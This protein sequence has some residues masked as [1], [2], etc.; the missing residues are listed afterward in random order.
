MTTP[1]TANRQG[2]LAG[3]AAGV[4]W[5]FVFLSPQIL[6]DFSP[7]AIALGRF[8][9]FGLISLIHARSVWRVWTVLDAKARC[10]VVALSAAGFW[11]YTV[12]LVWSVQ[13]NGAVITT[14]V[15]G[16]LPVTIAL[17][18]HRAWPGRLTQLGLALIVG[19]LLL[20]QA[21][22]TDIASA[23][24][25]V[26]LLGLGSLLGCVALWTWYSLAS[27]RFLHHHPQVPKNIFISMM[28]LISLIS[29]M[30]TAVLVADP[31]TLLQQP[32]L[33]TFG[34]WSLIVGVGA[35]WVAYWLWSLTTTHCPPRVSGP[36]IVS[37]TLFGLV[38]SFAYAQ[39][40]PEAHEAAAMAIFFAGALL[41]I[42]A[43][44]GRQPLA[45]N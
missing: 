3:L 28:G 37:E 21:G 15:I 38:Y 44:T 1:M 11:L 35:T 18:G 32:R 22:K 10:F 25:S 29:L 31:T 36:L 2:I 20:L 26:T 8:L 17:A 39:R 16:L 12:L 42:G 24:Q 34:I 45:A 23:T 27:A 41:C 4:L 6:H 33:G 13:H 7:F 9:C 19:G 43:K 14:L 5:G 40:W 30:A